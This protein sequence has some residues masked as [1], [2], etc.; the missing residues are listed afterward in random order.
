VIAAEPAV[1]HSVADEIPGPSGCGR[2]RLDQT[3]HL[4]RCAGNG[5]SAPRWRRD[6]RGAA[7]PSASARPATPRGLGCKVAR[8]RSSTAG[9]MRRPPEN[10]QIETG[11]ELAP[12]HERKIA[13]DGIHARH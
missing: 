2:T 5:T 12:T 4:A 10:H 7:P 9:T 6:P 13:P 3:L 11:I 8:A 1:H